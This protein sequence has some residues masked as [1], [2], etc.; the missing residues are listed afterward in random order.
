M[1]TG[2]PVVDATRS[3]RVATCALCR[4]AIVVLALLAGA[5]EVEAQSRVLSPSGPAGID[6]ALSSLLLTRGDLTLRDTPLVTALFS[7]SEIWKVNVVVGQEVQGQVNGVFRNA[8]LHEILES[9]LLSN[10]YGYRPAGKSLVVMQLEDLG[11]LNPMFQLVVVPLL[12]ADPAEIIDSAQL[13]NSP[14]GKIKAIPTTRSL[15]VLDFPERVARVRQ[16]VEELDAAAGQAVGEQQSGVGGPP[17]VV[18]FAPQHVAASSLLQ[19]VEA[20]LGGEG[21]AAVIEPDNRL[22]VSGHRAQ[23]ELARQVVDTLDVP[24]QQVRITALIYDLDVR[25]IERL[26]INWNHALRD[27]EDAQGNANHVF[28]IDSLLSVPVNANLP[29]GAM[30]FMSLS[31]NFEIT[32]VIKALQEA[33]DSRLLADPNVTVLDHERATM[34][35]VT[36][37]PYQEL[38]QTQQGGNIGTTNFREAGVKLEVTPH[39]AVDRTIRMEV[40]PSFSRLAG[41]TPGEP[42]Q[43]IIDRREAN[44]TVRVADGQVLVIGGLRQRNDTGDFNGLPFLKD[45]QTFN[46]GALFRGRETEVRESELVVFI[47]PQIVPVAFVGSCREDAALARGQCLL[48]QISA[49][50]GGRPPHRPVPRRPPTPIGG[51][52][53]LGTPYQP[54]TCPPPCFQI[55]R[56]P[57]HPPSEMDLFPAPHDED[58]DDHADRAMEMRK[59]DAA[60]T[61]TSVQRLSLVPATEEAVAAS[62]PARARAPATAQSPSMPTKEPSHWARIIGVRAI[63][64]P[65]PSRGPEPRL[66]QMSP[67][68]QKRGR[69]AAGTAEPADQYR[70]PQEPSD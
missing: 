49:A 10:G 34:S 33:K 40:T 66:R 30:T 43:P 20:T 11:D 57:L 29:D 36:E 2:V 60:S 68:V 14:Q 22:V 19:A 18:Q 24:R 23:L 64:R 6:P 3:V 35:I 61:P 70:R 53:V 46:L 1:T 48:D 59:A 21:K 17:E 51:P 31:R 69:S 67:L 56:P 62:W 54:D 7:I 41:Y 50:T 47:M 9:I 44:T 28:K 8:P 25:D 39:I 26:G 12:H 55:D 63:N 15:M 45:I 37:I 5:A 13:L 65:L 38:T 4:R 16:F 42:P 27:A 58:V 52:R 32:A